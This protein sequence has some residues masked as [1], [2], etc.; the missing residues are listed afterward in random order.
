MVL[1]AGNIWRVQVVENKPVI[2]DKAELVK[3]PGWI[4]CTEKDSAV[5][6]VWR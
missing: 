3:S 5:W 2:V 4:V 1:N 6:T